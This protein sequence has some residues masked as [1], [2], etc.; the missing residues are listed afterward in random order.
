[1]ATN[2]PDV[3]AGA[4]VMDAT[5]ATVSGAGARSIHSHDDRLTLL[6]TRMTYVSLTFFFACFY[7]AQIYLQILNQ[8]GLWLP[9][10][11]N[12][13]AS[14][15]G[16]VETGL[17]LLAGLIYFAGQWTGLY[18]RNFSRLS[19]ALWIAGVLTVISFI[20][21]VMEIVRPGFSLQ[22]GGYASVFAVTEG[23][24]TVIVLIS[25]ILLL[26]LA[27]RARLGLFKTSGVAVEAFGE[28]YGWLSAIALMNFLALYVQ[29]FFPS[30]G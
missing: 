1:M 4:T 3:G 22:A 12:H 9:A 21:H 16:V 17:I 20:I 11:V 27:N 30:G 28:Y 26:G 15:M 25:A 14:W 19:A 23:V 2:P 24:F 8:N 10:G 5:A 29:P 6:A 13:P 18:Q 7:F